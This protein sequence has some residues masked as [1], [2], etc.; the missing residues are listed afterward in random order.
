MFRGLSV[1]ML[2][3]LVSCAK[4]AEPNKM[5]FGG[6]TLMGTRNYILDWRP[7]SCGKEHCCGVMP[8]FSPLCSTDVPL[9]QMILH[10][11]LMTH[12]YH[13]AMWP[14]HHH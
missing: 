3:T 13:T 10:L 11:L 6:Q 7:D 2:G 4:T 1:C 8:E 5:A 14:A 9:C 12:D